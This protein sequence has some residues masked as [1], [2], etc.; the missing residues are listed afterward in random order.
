MRISEKLLLLLSRKPKGDD[1]PQSSSN[2][3]LNNGLDLLCDAFPHILT[4]INDKVILDF[5]CGYGAQA[6]ELVNRG[7]M[8][9]VGVDKNPQALKRAINHAKEEGVEKQTQFKEVLG[10]DEKEKFDII[11]SQNSMEHFKDPIST[12]N[13]MKTIISKKGKIYVTFVNPWFAPYGCHMQFFTKMPWINILFSEK[14]V[15]NVRRHFRQDGASKYEEV[16][17]GLNK[18]SVIKFERLVSSSGL[19]VVYKKYRCIKNLNLF[20]KLPFFRELVINRVDCILTI[21]KK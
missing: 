1:Y 5:G 2:I 6:I 17:W 19:K 13:E 16:E 7:A 3:I 11:I 4:D 9:V 12:L 8:F 15:M 14:T 21:L 20:S 18:M 10:K